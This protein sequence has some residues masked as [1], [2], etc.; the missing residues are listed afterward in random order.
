MRREVAWLISL[1]LAAASWLT[2][3]WLGYALVAPGAEGSM[4]QN[5][6]SAHPYFAS[7]A[8]LIACVV[9]L[10]AVGLVLCAGEGLR[11]RRPSAPP[12]RLFAL[13]PPLGFTVQEHLEHLFTSGSLPYDLVLEPTFVTG[14]VLQLPFALC[15]LL[16][17]RALFAL[18][19]RLGH[20]LAAAVAVPR[21]PS[22][23][24]LALFRLPAP[25]TLCTPSPLALGHGQ[26]GPPAACRA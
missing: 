16:L 7:Q 13:L 23:L 1:P 15:A 2:A 12:A 8:I 9:T 14:L 10:V 3:H 24:P 20:A 25:P 26:R 5:A 6:E 18:G 22:A 11:G 17:S 21:P 19:Y 4:R